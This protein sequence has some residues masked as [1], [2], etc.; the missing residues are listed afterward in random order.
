LRRGLTLN[1]HAGRQQVRHDGPVRHADW[2]PGVSRDFGFATGAL[3]LVGTNANETACASPSN[4][5]FLAGTALMS[6][7]SKT[8]WWRTSAFT[9][10]LLGVLTSLQKF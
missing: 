8:F 1:V 5:K 3:T 7:V 10:R 6:S 4:A 2:K 9:T